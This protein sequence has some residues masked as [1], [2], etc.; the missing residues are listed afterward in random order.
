MNMVSINILFH[1]LLQ[2][3]L[4][5]VALL[6]QKKGINCKTITILKSK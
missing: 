3:Q 2:K 4:N 6:V 1:I 5:G